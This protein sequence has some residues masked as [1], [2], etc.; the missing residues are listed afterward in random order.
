VGTPKDIVRAHVPL[1]GLDSTQNAFDSLS[2]I[3]EERLVGGAN[4][5]DPSLTIPPFRIDKKRSG[6]E[7][8]METH[9]GDDDDGMLLRTSF[10]VERFMWLPN[11]KNA[12]NGAGLRV[13]KI[14]CKSRGSF[15]EDSGTRTSR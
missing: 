13:R 10:L 14:L 7:Q 4:S 9:V 5:F 6:D 11:C 8:Q 2:S 12:E 15:E 1:M 3:R